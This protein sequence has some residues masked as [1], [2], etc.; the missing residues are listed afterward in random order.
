[1]TRYAEF[2]PYAGTV[3]EVIPHL[4]LVENAEPPLAEIAA[5]VARHLPFERSVRAI[6]VLVEGGDGQWR[7]HWRLPLRAEPT[8]RV[9]P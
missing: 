1:M 7:L 2:P 4:T 3:D 6:E 9:R 5:E 8:R